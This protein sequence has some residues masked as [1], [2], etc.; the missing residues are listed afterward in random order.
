MWSGVGGSLA[1]FMGVV[2]RFL[3]LLKFL[4]IFGLVFFLTIFCFP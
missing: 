1:I 3:R 2:K 4:A